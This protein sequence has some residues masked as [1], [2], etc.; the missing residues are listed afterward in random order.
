M[1]ERFWRI[2]PLPGTYLCAIV[3]CLLVR[4]PMLSMRTTAGMHAAC[5]QYETQS[6]KSFYTQ[7]SFFLTCSFYGRCFS[8]EAVYNVLQL[9]T[10]YALCI[11]LSLGDGLND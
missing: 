11:V 2:K 6:I 1:P 4:L 9:S 10:D 8:A 7:T 3:H 5:L